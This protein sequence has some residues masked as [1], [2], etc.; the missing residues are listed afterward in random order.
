MVNVADGDAVEEGQVLLVMES[1]KMELSIT[2]PQAGTVAGLT[3]APG[4]RVDRHQPLVAVTA[5]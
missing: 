1:M 4:D 2:A 3:L 5:A